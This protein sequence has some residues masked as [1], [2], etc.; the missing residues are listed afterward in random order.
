MSE[1]RAD[2]A[3]FRSGTFAV[4]RGRTYAAPAAPNEQGEIALRPADAQDAPE[5]GEALTVPMEELEAW[6]A[7]SWTFQWSGEPFSVLET[8]DGLVTGLYKGGQYRFAWEYL[9][10]EL[11]EDGGHEIYTVTL[12]RESVENLTGHRTDLLVHWKEDRDS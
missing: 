1:N 4:H 8:G 6:Y 3:D 12:E 7:L 5:P 11:A 2:E 10:R 9:D